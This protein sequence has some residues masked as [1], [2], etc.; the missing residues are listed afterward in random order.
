MLGWHHQFSYQY[1]HSQI[2]HNMTCI[3][4]HNATPIGGYH[5]VWCVLLIGERILSAES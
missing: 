4:C 5:A 1:L 3:E 2:V